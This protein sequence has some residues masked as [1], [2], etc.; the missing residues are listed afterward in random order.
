MPVKT[1]NPAL[2]II[3][4]QNAID[5]YGEGERTNPELEDNLENMLRVWRS[6]NLPIIHVRHSSRTPTSS[7][8]RDS[9]YFSFKDCVTPH[10]GETIVTKTEHS[11]F[12]ETELDG[13]LKQNHISELVV[14]G[15]LINNSVD[16]TVRNAVNMGYRVL[17]P[18]D[19]TAAYTLSMLNGKVL[20]SEDVHQIFLSNLA[21]DYCTAT[22]S[23]K[24]I[25]AL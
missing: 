17:L 19:L 13:L 1:N 5:H 10:D 15:V 9:G 25:E 18:E 24:I 23:R 7:Y 2:M 22:S 12:I 21:A 4:V 16:A 8:H 20:S 6:K 14:A 11:A 3:D